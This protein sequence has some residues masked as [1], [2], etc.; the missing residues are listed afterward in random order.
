MPLPLI[1][2]RRP[3]LIL[4]LLLAVLLWGGLGHAQSGDEPPAPLTPGLGS[5][6]AVP[7]L[8][9]PR[10][11]PPPHPRSPSQ[12][13][14]PFVV[15]VIPATH[16]QWE[17]TT[18]GQTA[19]WRLRVAAA[20][21]VSLNLGFTRYWMPDGGRL[22][23][24][25]PDYAEVIGPFT[26]ADNE[27]HGQLWTP[28]LPGGAVVIEVA[29]AASRVEE[30]ELEL[31]AVNRGYRELD[32]ATPQ[33]RQELDPAAQEPRSL[34]TCR[35]SVACS[36]ADPYRD[37]VRSVAKIM[38][39]GEA[40]CS[41]VLLNNTERD[42][43]PY[44]LTARHCFY[45]VSGRLAN[46][47]ASLV[48]YWNYESPTCGSLGGG[49]Q[50]Q[51]Q[52]GAYAR[53]DNYTTDFILLELDDPPD[54]AH[55]VYFAGWDR[56]SAIPTSAVGI[57]HPV[58][59][60]K[61]ISIT[62]DPPTVVDAPL[63]TAHPGRAFKVGW[64]QGRTTRGSSGSPLFDQNKRVVG[65]LYGGDS[66]CGLRGSSY[67]PRLAS[68][69]VGGR[70]Q[71]WNL[72]YWLDPGRTG[73]TA[74]DG[75]NNL[76][77]SVVAG[78]LGSL[79]LL[80]TDTAVEI[81][82]A[83]AFLSPNEAPLTY[84]L[85]SSDSSVA[86]ASVS[87]STLTVTPVA[88]GV[89][90]IRVTAEGTAILPAPRWFAVTVWPTSGVDYD[91][92][93]DGLIDIRTLIQFNAIRY[94]RDGD[95]R[96]DTAAVAYASAF[97]GVDEVVCGGDAGC[98]GYELIADLDFDTNGNGRNDP[99]DLY[100]NHGAGWETISALRT[101]LEGNGHA[102]SGLYSNYHYLTD[103]IPVPYV[104][105][106]VKDSYGLFRRIAP[107]GVV[108][109]LRLLE[110]D[111]AGNVYVGSLAARNAGRVTAVSVTGK[112]EAPNFAVSGIGSLI[113]YNEV[114]GRIH[115][116]SAS[117]RVW[118]WGVGGGLVGWNKGRIVASYT[119]GRV[120][121]RIGNEYV[122]SA[123]MEA[124]LGG[125]VG[126]NE[127]SITASSATGRVSGW[128]NIGGLVGN[129]RKGNITASSATGQVSSG[130][131]PGDPETYGW[132]NIGGLVGNNYRGSITVSYATGRVSGGSET[133]GLVGNNDEGSLT[134]SYATGQVDGIRHVG[135]LV[136][137][138]DE[139][140]L[141]A[142]YATGRVT[143]KEHVG[144]LV[145]TNEGS[146]TASYWDTTTSGQ[147]SGA[148]GRSTA[149]L[150][151]PT[152]YSGIYQTW[153]VDV[154][155]DSTA[156]DPWDFGTSS[157]YPLL[158]A[159]WDGQ[160]PET[161]QEFGSQFRVGPDSQQF[162]KDEPVGTLSDRWLHAGDTAGVE[163]GEAFE[164]P[165]GDPLTYTASSSATGVVMVS[166]SG[167]RVTITP[168]G[169]GTAT[170]TVTAT[171]AGG[172]IAGGT[173]TLTVTVVPSSAVDYD[174]DDD[175]LIEITTLARLDAIRHDLD[176][177]GVPTTDGATAY[178]AAFPAVGDRQ[179]CGGLTGCVGYELGA[180]LDFDTNNSGSAD[181]GDTY[182]NSGAGWEPLDNGTAFGG[183][184]AIFEGNGHTIANLFI[185]R[186]SDDVGL[187]GRTV[188]SV[189]RHVGLIDVEVSGSSN[190]G[191]LA[192]VDQGSIIG[193]YV[194][195][196][197]TGTG[198]DV[199]GLVGQK[200]GRS[201]VTSYAAVEVTGE[202]NVGGLIGENNA[203][204]TAS[205]ATGRVTGEENVGG[206]VGSNGKTITASYATGTVRGESNVGGLVGS[207]RS[208]SSTG[209]V[210]ASY[211]DT[212]TSRRTTSAGGAG[213]DDGA[214]AGADGLHRHL[215]AVE[216]GPGQRQHERRSVGLRDGR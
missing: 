194:T 205:Y 70:D 114:S 62:D 42:G 53:A 66:T 176:G 96:P 98:V 86:T 13:A 200:Y 195:G 38:I 160:D 118:S 44:F 120:V 81:E 94:D 58:D 63:L 72:N 92:D 165:E 101:T 144:G 51:F 39:A 210:T 31:G 71:D 54:P 59:T 55:N 20:G 184:R 132:S 153:N 17:T 188:S 163:V 187:F 212:T 19:V 77:V 102:I 157:Q 73:K 121:S 140:S 124:H 100:W 136:G 211:W 116:S 177:D 64:E 4:F 48:V 106:P 83:D 137:N 60:V 178:A 37:Q 95:G 129:N 22:L 28:L 21:A 198:G 69:W 75:V 35:I 196:M 61:L 166:V 207:N 50:A 133:G 123:A 161:W 1:R 25:T 151:T 148:H 6:H 108:R 131:E 26:A 150:Q 135:G 15:Q 149:Q 183:F 18:D 76:R 146:L 142:S 68:S 197:V 41:G 202:D 45:S 147:T 162:D 113:G 209:T 30:L 3:L 115:E 65:Q 156:D 143:G 14:V 141:T 159:D 134:A 216:R 138:N 172:S 170:I 10:V 47:A 49:S 145:G 105:E 215:L 130:R 67:Y 56:S 192:G 46:K 34:T 104:R 206:L 99:S 9:T 90:Y 109:N 181:A 185:D 29:V 112:V 154:D 199:G 103:A 87:G 24:Y 16:G 7:V 117:A 126:L 85:Y 2:R 168:V 191:G 88:E 174:T 8:Q 171:D 78:A 182:W 93:D 125:L 40:E 203:I 27:V 74:I 208:S 201:V 179:A 122:P 43:K 33:S 52:T 107:H 204:L 89:S 119:T 213:P 127:G 23:V 189:I 152:G 80:V 82:L 84:T 167:S 32:S 128:F 214:V 180:N 110:I 36:V 91:Q 164:D 169:A 139:G 11:V 190:V 173:Q 79:A 5:L 158:K 155:G 193:S 186:D 97:P 12:F 175:G 111:L 57:H